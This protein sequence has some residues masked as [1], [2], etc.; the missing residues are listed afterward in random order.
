MSK[1][2]K[3]SEKIVEAPLISPKEPS[4]PPK[5][6]LVS[7][8]DSPNIN[9]KLPESPL[10]PP[11]EPSEAPKEPS[12][13]PKVLKTKRKQSPKQLENLSKGGRKKRMETPKP[14]NGESLE[15][16]KGN[17]NKTVLYVG[18]ALGIVA[19]SIGLWKLYTLWKNKQKESE[20]ITEFDDHIPEL[21]VQTK[22]DLKEQARKL[23]TFEEAQR[24]FSEE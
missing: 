1:S 7:P 18:I 5:N 4:E 22:R 19:S 23:R 2:P 11:K 17:N 14:S 24:N 3:V 20:I 10:I 13:A 12:E 15:T 21:D 8:K 6:P 9:N 16:P